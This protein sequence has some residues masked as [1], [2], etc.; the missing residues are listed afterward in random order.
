MDLTEQVG[1]CVAGFDVSYAHA[2]PIV[3]HSLPLLPVDP[4]VELSAPCPTS[5]LPAG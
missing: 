4:D 1:H 5:C 2:K 3:P